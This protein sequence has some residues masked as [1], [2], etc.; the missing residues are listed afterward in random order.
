MA[1]QRRAGLTWVELFIVIGILTLMMALLLPMVQNAREQARKASWKNYLKSIGLALHNYHDTY[2]FFPPG[3]IIREDDV[4]MHGWL[5]MIMPYLDANPLSVMIDYD[6][7]WGHPANIPVFK[8]SIPYY[9]IPD[10]DLGLTS[11]GHGL[12][13]VLGNPNLMHRNSSVRLRELKGGAAHNWFA[14]EIAGNYQ[15]WGYP[16]NWRPLGTKLC[17]G[18][19]SF[20]HSAW[21]GGHLL[22][23]DGRVSFFSDETSPEILRRLANAPPVATRDQTAVPDK[24]FQIGNFYWD[25][26]ELQSDPQGKNKYLV[27]V[28]HNPTGTPLQINVHVTKRFTPEELTYHKT[29]IEVLHLLSQITPSTDVASTL[30]AT[31]LA[32]ATSPAQFAANVKTLESLQKQLLKK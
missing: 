2:R 28:L 10:V 23:V 32:E 21:D 1:Q 25:R 17:D 18:P 4:A 11:A 31:T 24:T 14:G 30:K 16:F 19:E 9:M 27:Q 22:L 6:Q 20:G 5:M 26:F 7:P 15:P 13:Q 3:G 12:T 8:R 29:S